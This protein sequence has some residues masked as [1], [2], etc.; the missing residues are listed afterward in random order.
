MHN[1]GFALDGA[2]RVL[3]A[4]LVLGAG[5]PVLF[6]LGIRSL[7]WGAG[8]AR[9]SESGVTVAGS[10]RPLGTVIGY[11][12]FAVVVLGV[13]LGL[14][15]IVSSGFGYKLDFSGFFPTLVAK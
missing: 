9:V 15:F 4:G 3:L 14:L 12:L 10:R 1:L 13:L 11:L 8:E 7:A 5:L 6:A 2:W